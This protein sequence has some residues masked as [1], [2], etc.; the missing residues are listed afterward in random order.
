[1]EALQAFR[2]LVAG[3]HWTLRF[4]ECQLKLVHCDR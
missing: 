3:A 4:C 1:M 2:L